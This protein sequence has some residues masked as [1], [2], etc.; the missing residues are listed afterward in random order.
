MTKAK[1][2]AI[3]FRRNIQKI[4]LLID[5]ALASNA[6]QNA[7]LT[8]FLADKLAEYQTRSTELATEKTETDTI[9]A[10]IAGGIS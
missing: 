4:N 8:A 6:V 3:Y 7:T 2:T 1:A 9:I 10:E 5:F